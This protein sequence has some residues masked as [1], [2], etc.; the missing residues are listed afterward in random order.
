[1]WWII[2]IGIIAG[3]LPLFLRFTI[4]E[5]GT[6]KIIMRWGGVVKVFIQWT[7]YKL[8]PE[9]NVEPVT[10]ATRP[11][12][13]GLRIW[14]GTPFDKVHRFKLR[15]HSIE[16]V[17]GKRIPVF[18]EEMKD[19]VMLRPDRYWIKMVRV[20][21]KDGMFPE[22]EWLIGMRCINPE[23]TIFKSPHN[24]VENA[25]TQLEPLLRQYIYTKTIEEVL[26]LKGEEIWKD[27]GN[28]RVIQEVLR[29]EWGIQ[30][31]PNEIAIFNVD[32]PS[33]YQEALARQKQTELETKAR[34]A[35]ETQEREAEKI[36]LQHVRDRAKELIEGVKLSP[37]DAIE[38]VQTERG[39]VT[40]HIIEYK[41]LENL[42]GLPLIIIGGTIPPKEQRRE[43]RRKG[44]KPK[45]GELFY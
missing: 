44:K 11:W 28:D 16:E 42:R 9:G 13:G 33:E 27:I 22:I 1:M 43:E 12:Y 14:L 35:A 17:E 26:K 18:H 39:K 38:V 15:W 34:I 5:E 31:D 3:I 25:L 21:T 41:G 6:A 36:E 10:P 20:E 40:K 19:C 2:L 8:T 7:G 24:W 45:R 32:L 4:V 23:K 37:K 29:N 30:I